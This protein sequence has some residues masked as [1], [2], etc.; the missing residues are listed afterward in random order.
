[1]KGIILA[2]GSGSRLYPIT[3]SISKQLL[4][5]YNKPMIYYPLSTL[6]LAGIKEILIISTPYHIILYKDLLGNGSNIGIKL[7][8]K[9]QNNPNGLA[10]AFILGKKFIGNSDVCLILGDNIFYGNGFSERLKSYVDFVKNNKKA[11]VLGYKVDNPQSF[12]IASFDRNNNVVSI[13][14][15]PKNPKSNVAVIGLYFYPNNVIDMVKNVKKSARGE[16]EISSLN[17]EYLDLNSLSIDVLKEWVTWLDTGTHESIL[18]AS[19][20]IHSINKQLNLN[21]GC[22]EEVAFRM[23][24]ISLSE[25][26]GIINKMPSSSYKV[27]LQNKYNQ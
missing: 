13:E 24:F 26:I 14:E 23:N 10:E 6:M 20:F 25:L 2:G 7:T 11:K 4:G 1:M 22:I 17:K 18:E 8:Y 9:V 16:L 27:Y 3:K 15:K 21:V 19:N 12:G 5:V